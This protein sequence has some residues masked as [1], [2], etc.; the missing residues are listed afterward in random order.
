MSNTPVKY[1]NVNTKKLQRGA[2]RKLLIK[3]NR[4]VE[5]LY[6][7]KCSTL[8]E[9]IYPKVATITAFIVCNLFSA[10]SKTTEAVLSKTSSVTSI[11]SRPNF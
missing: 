7:F 6:Y 1:L 11:A 5:R 8:I 3:R 10:S 9:I 4:I 2:I